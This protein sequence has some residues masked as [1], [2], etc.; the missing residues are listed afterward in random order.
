M[1][2]TALMLIAIYVAL[3]WGTYRKFKQNKILLSNLRSIVLA[4]AIIIIF[5]G[6]SILKD[7]LRGN[8]KIAFKNFKRIINYPV[9][10]GELI[11]LSLEVEAQRIVD[12]NK[13]VV[14]IKKKKR[15]KKQPRVLEF[16]KDFVMMLSSFGFK[17]DLKHS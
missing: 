15:A 6:I 12:Q 11:E 7:L 9:Y 1:Y 14:S 17:R 8:A 13:K 10:L 16:D 2:M 5:N 3:V 4:P